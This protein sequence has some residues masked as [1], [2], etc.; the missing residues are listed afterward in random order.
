ML[1]PSHQQQTENM[2]W[3]QVDNINVAKKIVE[4]KVYDLSFY[5][6]YVKEMFTQ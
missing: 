1:V 3:Y 4:K 5:A 2:K 6:N